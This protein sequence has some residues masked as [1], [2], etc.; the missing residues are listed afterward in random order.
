MGMEARLRRYLRDADIHALV[1]CKVGANR[2]RIFLLKSGDGGEEEHVARVAQIVKEPGDS[3]RT[4]YVPVA[5]P[6]AEENPGLL[7]DQDTLDVWESQDEIAKAAHRFLANGPRLLSQHFGTDPVQ[8]AKLVENAVALADFDVGGTTIKEGTW[9]VGLEFD[10][11]LRELVTKGEIDAVSIEGF[12]TRVAKDA[13]GLG[14]ST[15]NDDAE[16]AFF[17]ELAFLD[18]DDRALLAKGRLERVPGKQN[19]I[20]RLPAPMR[21]AWHRSIIYRAAVHIHEE[22][23]RPVGMAIA[24]AINWAKHICATGDVKQWKGPQQVSPKSRAETCAAVALWNSMKAHARA[25]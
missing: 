10:D 22:R 18:H 11:P 5:V 13:D 7:G 6:G 25:T 16:A 19:W 20:E 1:L 21:A 24:S 8:G 15:T 4:A 17:D 3:W 9:Y 23:G 2:Q 12:A 14:M